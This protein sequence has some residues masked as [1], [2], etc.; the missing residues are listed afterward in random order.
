M[1]NYN[2]KIANANWD[3][4]TP[5][6][7]E[8]MEAPTIEVLRKLETGNQSFPSVMVN[9]SRQT[10]GVLSNAKGN[11]Q[12]IGGAYSSSDSQNRVPAPCV[13]TKALAEATDRGRKPLATPLAV[14][15]AEFEEISHLDKGSAELSNTNQSLTNFAKEAIAAGGAPKLLE[16]VQAHNHVMRERDTQVETG[17]YQGFNSQESGHGL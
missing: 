9:A 15:T 1:A 2:A 14:S 3:T 13:D 17:Q 5:G 8:S 6:Q 16:F 12:N 7:K 4:L 11:F 10:A